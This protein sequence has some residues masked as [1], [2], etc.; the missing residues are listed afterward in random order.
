MNPKF[1]AETIGVKFWLSIG[2]GK[3]QSFVYSCV[4]IIRN[5]VLF[6]FN[7]NLLLVVQ[8]NSFFVT[9]V[10]LNVLELMAMF[11]KT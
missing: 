1:R 3:K 7:F 2:V 5:S 11:L 10:P 8:W 6:A 4:P 9:Q